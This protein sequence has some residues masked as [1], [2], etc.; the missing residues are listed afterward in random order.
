MQSA[1]VIQPTSITTSQLLEVMHTRD[2]E[3]VYTL[4]PPQITVSD[5]L[6]NT[7]DPA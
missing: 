5:L 7:L 4:N 1:R 3:H 2:A 6:A